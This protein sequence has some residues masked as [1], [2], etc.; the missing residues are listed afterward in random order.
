M[1]RIADYISTI[2]YIMTVWV[3]TVIEELIQTK[4]FYTLSHLIGSFCIDT[5][6]DD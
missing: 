6:D 5:V 4:L 3:E 2:D 1:E